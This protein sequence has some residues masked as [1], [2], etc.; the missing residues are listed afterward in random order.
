MKIDY[1]KTKLDL[2]LEFSLALDYNIG[3]LNNYDFLTGTNISHLDLSCLVMS[4]DKYLTVLV[5]VAK[6][7]KFLYTSIFCLSTW[8][9]SF[10]QPLMVWKLL[11]TVNMKPAQ[12]KLLLSPIL[13]CLSHTQ[14][15]NKQSLSSPLKYNHASAFI[16]N[17]FLV[18]SGTQP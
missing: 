7:H 9:L 12:T 18:F 6:V 15:C 5:P 1:F 2:Y 17:L 16:V 4:P 11:D 10:T 14:R 8:N 3:Q 13:I